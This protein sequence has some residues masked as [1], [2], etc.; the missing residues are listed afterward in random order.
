MSDL[1]NRINY[2]IL[3]QRLEVIPSDRLNKLEVRRDNSNSLNP[4]GT[5][6]AP[7]PGG[8]FF[9]LPQSNFTGDRYNNPSGAKP[10]PSEG[11]TDLHQFH[12]FGGKIHMRPYPTNNGATSY[13]PPE[14]WKE[15]TPQDVL[16][17]I[18]QNKAN[19]E[20][21]LAPTNWRS[22]RM[23]RRATRNEPKTPPTTVFGRRN[24]VSVYKKPNIHFREIKEE[25]GGA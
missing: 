2:F 3:S 23:L 1:V 10:R 6:N 13:T 22:L 16:N 4:H 5:G 15:S 8:R 7:V 20:F 11:S 24:P 18:Q 17:Y 12:K 14:A 25:Q 21:Y 9:E 19:P